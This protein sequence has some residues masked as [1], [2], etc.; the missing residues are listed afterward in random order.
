MKGYL[1][2]TNILSEMANQKPD[3]A[4]ISLISSLNSGFLS[5]ITLHE[6]S[7]GLNRLPDG[8]RKS[9]LSKIMIDLLD[10][11]ENQVFSVDAQIAQSAG[12]LRVQSQR[13]GSILHMADA[14]IAATASVHELVLVT[15]NVSDF[16]ALSISLFNPWDQ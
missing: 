5:T 2:D 8:Q 16:R 11:F 14:L 6:I 15:R 3:E 12:E 4:V 10:Q 13:R 1:F 7:Y 9:R